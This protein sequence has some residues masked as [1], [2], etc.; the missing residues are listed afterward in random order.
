M[1]VATAASVPSW[2]RR[3]QQAGPV[4]T[5]SELTLSFTSPASSSFYGFTQHYDA[6]MSCEPWHDRHIDRRRQPLLNHGHDGR[7]MVEPCD[8]QLLLANPNP[9]SSNSVSNKSNSSDAAT[10]PAG[11]R[12]R[13]PKFT[14]LTAENLKILCSALEARV[15]RHRDLAAG[16]A[17]A[18]LQR[19]SG[20]TRTTRPSSSATWLLFQGR[21][22]HG[23]AAMARE[24][25]RLVFGSY[26]EF[27]CIT[28]AKLALLA[29]SGD[30][31]KRQRS[32]ADNEQH[33]YMQRFYEA[34]RENPHRVVMIDGVEHDYSE[35]AGIKNAMATG[36]VRG[37][38]GDAVSLEDAIVVSCQVSGSRSR[39]SSPRPVKQRRFMGEIIVDSKAEDDGAEK[40]AVPRY[41]LDLNACAAMDAEGEEAGSS[42]PNDDMEILKDA[43]GVF[44][45]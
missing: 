5:G 34:I 20:V 42:S 22:D 26:A 17:S 13:R 41:G 36:T 45:F 29:P 2:I 19:R 21:D 31:L 10:E 1:A 9:G 28:A 25:A 38:G 12:H 23:K 16:I 18:V 40:G 14:E 44:F 8:Q 15:S 33:G 3:S 6:N 32:P 39:V 43:D 7:P 24:L 37:C 35:A 4:L 30:C 27:T 11:A